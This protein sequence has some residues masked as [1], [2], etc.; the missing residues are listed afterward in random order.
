MNNPFENAM[1]QLERAAS[2]AGV[3]SSVI[4]KLQ[5]PD[6]VL[7]F[8][9]PLTMDNGTVRHFLAYRVQHDRSRGPYKGGFR[10]HPQVNLDEAKAL[11]FW[12]TVK[13][14]V[15]GVPFGGA[16]GGIQVDPKTLSEGEL[17]RLTRAYARLLAPHVGPELDVPA[18]DV[19]TNPTVMGW[20]VDEFQKV[21]GTK[22]PAVVTGK[23][24][25]QGG[26]EGR[27]EATGYGG[28]YILEEAFR[29]LQLPIPPRVVVQGFGN[30]G[31]YFADAAHNAGFKVT[32]VSDSK[33]GVKDKRGFGMSPHSI[34]EMKHSRCMISN[35][36]C[37]GSVCDCENYDAVTNEELLQLETDVLVPA[38]LE[39]QLT[40]ENAEKVQA[41]IILELANG[42]TTPEADAIFRKR[43][44]PVIPDVL[45]NAGG[46]TVSYF[47][48][49][50]NMHNEKWKREDVFKK[51]REVMMSAMGSVWETHERLNTDLRTAAFVV[52]LKRIEEAL[53]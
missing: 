50:Q 4:A 1:Q 43:G 39:N 52:A 7:E 19:N 2:V 5:K 34:Q 46:V 22:A 36:Y 47:E 14:A 10:Y 33:G 18:P 51:L 37:I 17:E 38:A 27:T 21:T 45:A 9:I 24:V 28:F 32:A 20:F 25:D 42:P 29:R 12:M 8:D 11:A 44:I 40:N 49:Y 16:K 23:S 3:K 35:C 30:V 26:S 13:T 31:Y 48:W 6:A 15:V 53:K 41:K